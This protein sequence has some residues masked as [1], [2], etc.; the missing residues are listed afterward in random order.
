MIM[1]TSCGSYLFAQLKFTLRSNQLDQ[2]YSEAE[3]QTFKARSQSGKYW[4]P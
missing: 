2:Y 1:L 3:Q 4:H